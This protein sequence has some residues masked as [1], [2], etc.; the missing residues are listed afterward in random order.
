[1][2]KMKSICENVKIAVLR[3]EPNK[4][5]KKKKKEKTNFAKKNEMNFKKVH[6]KFNSHHS[7]QS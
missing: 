5:K 7:M 2:K 6:V 1:M 4:K 3:W